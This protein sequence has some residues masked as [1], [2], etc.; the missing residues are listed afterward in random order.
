MCFLCLFVAIDSI[1]R[2]VFIRWLDHNRGMS[3]LRL[4][5]FLLWLAAASIPALAQ[6]DRITAAVESQDWATARS[7]IN[8]LRS[9]N[10]SVFREKNY[11]YLLG[12]IAERT[13]D[14]AAATASY[15]T[16]ASSE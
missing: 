12:R 16:I 7:E 2:L 13:G 10:E 6:P 1:H 9:S 15:Q 4:I 11:E 8:K 3:L 14:L 5:L